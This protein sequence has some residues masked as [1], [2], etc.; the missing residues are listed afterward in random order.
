MDAVDL[1]QKRHW[2]VSAG[3]RKDW[4]KEIGVV[5]AKRRGEA[6]QKKSTWGNLFRNTEVQINY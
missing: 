3:K 2:K 5:T 6:P 4:R 1:L